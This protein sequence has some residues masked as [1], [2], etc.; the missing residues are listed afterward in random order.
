MVLM[1]IES[2]IAEIH[3]PGNTH[4]YSATNQVFNGEDKADCQNFN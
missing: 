1:T 3:Y 4:H 2:C